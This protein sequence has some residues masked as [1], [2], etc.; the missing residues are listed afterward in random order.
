MWLALMF[1]VNIFKSVP[2]CD[3]HLVSTGATLSGID[4]SLKYILPTASTSVKCP[5]S[6]ERPA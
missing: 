2:G 4:W 6:A 5:R 1:G 3:F